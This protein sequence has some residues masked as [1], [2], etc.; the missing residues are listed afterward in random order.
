MVIAF[1]RGRPVVAVVCG[2]VVTTAAL[3]LAPAAQAAPAAPVPNGL[4]LTHPLADNSH[5][6]LGAA[7]RAATTAAV[8]LNY[9][10]QVQQN[11]EWCWAAD[12]ASIEQFHGAPTSQEEFCAAGKGTSPGYCPNEAAQID[13]I[14]NGFHGTGFSAESAGGAVSFST[15][16]QQID[17]GDPALTGIY[18]STGGGHAEVI[19]GYDAANRSIDVGDPWPTY[20]RYRTQSYDDYLQNSQFT[21]GDTVVGIAGR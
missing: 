17:A 21:W 1:D 4:T 6:R 19:Y 15:I 20:Q 16:T 9:S 2:V 18:W 8:S 5:F 11:D 13:E 10:Q 14:V 12:G 7:P 3:V